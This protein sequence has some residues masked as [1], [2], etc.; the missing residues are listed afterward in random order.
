MGNKMVDGTKFLFLFCFLAFSLEKCTGNRL[1]NDIVY[2]K[3]ETKTVKVDAQCELCEFFVRELDA[4]LEKS[5]F[6]KSVVAEVEKLCMKMMGNSSAICK[7]AGTYA[8]KIIKNFLE[9]ELVPHDVCV[10]IKYCQASNQKRGVGFKIICDMCKKLVGTLENDFIAESKLLIAYFKKS[11]CDKLPSP[12]RS[13]CDES[14]DKD[15]EAR[16]QQLFK[17]ILS[18]ANICK[19]IKMCS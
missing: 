15:I 8:D 4:Y 17:T 11:F 6:E 13:K 3:Q 16:L 1:P 19:D 10:K 12:T 18:A 5:S 14:L 9:K 7:Q 2:M